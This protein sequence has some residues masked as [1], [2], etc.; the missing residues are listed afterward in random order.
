MLKTRVIKFIFV[1]IVC[2]SCL[3]QNK[4][5][6]NKSALINGVLIPKLLNNPFASW[7]LIN[8]DFLLPHITHF[9]NIIVLLLLVFETLGFMFSVSFL[10]F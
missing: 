1:N 2:I 5:S 4:V 8:I 7:F 9:D 6:P 10:H 3:F